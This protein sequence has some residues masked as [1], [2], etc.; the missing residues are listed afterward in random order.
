MQFQLMDVKIVLFYQVKKLDTK[1]LKFSN[2]SCYN[3]FFIQ[4]FIMDTQDT[5][6]MRG[7]HTLLKI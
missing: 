7:L 6:S 3:Y 5:R 2:M 1:I 4:V